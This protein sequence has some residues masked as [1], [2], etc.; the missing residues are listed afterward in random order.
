MM[1]KQ[2]MPLKNDGYYFKDSRMITGRDK[3]L[4]DSDIGLQV[5]LVNGFDSTE[6]RFTGEYQ[7]SM[8]Y[9]VVVF[10]YSKTP[11]YFS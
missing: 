7:D 5:D 1:L 10:R 9:G 8:K 11:K 4:K 3:A 2:V 6:E